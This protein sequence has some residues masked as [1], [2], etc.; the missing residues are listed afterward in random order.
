MATAVALVNQLTGGIDGL[1]PLEAPRSAAERPPAT[2]RRPR[3]RRPP[4]DRRRPRHVPC[5][6]AEDELREVLVSCGMGDV[7]AAAAAVNALLRRSGAAPH[8]IRHDTEPWHLHFHSADAGVIAG[9]AAGY[10]MGLAIV[11]GTGHADRLGVCTAQPCDR[12]YVDLSRNGTRRFCS[13]RCA[14]RISVAARRASR[15][16]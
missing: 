3:P 10:A 1:H 5:S 15:A 12:V 6:W 7:D 2:R 9:W 8:L 13:T 16:R 14:N 4:A 11:I